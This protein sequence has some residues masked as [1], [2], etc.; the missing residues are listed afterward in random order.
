MFVV[1]IPAGLGGGAVGIHGDEKFL[2][3]DSLFAVDRFAG[4]FHDFDF[5]F[6]KISVGHMLFVDGP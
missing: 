6:F 5:R 2:A 4:V 3:A 1:T